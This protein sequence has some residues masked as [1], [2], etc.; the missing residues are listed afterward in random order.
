MKSEAI[1]RRLGFIIPIEA[2]C[3]G[4]SKVSLTTYSTFSSLRS[5][6]VQLVNRSYLGSSTLAHF[7]K[8]ESVVTCPIRGLSS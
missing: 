3:L 6:L 2:G 8:L 5:S 4:L 7:S 1:N